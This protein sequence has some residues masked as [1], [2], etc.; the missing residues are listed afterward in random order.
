MWRNWTICE[1]VLLFRIFESI[2]RFDIQS[3]LIYIGTNATLNGMG[4]GVHSPCCSPIISLAGFN[5]NNAACGF[6]ID[7]PDAQA[8]LII[9]RTHSPI[10]YP[11]MLQNTNPLLYFS[12][13]CIY[14]CIYIHCVLCFS[15]RESLA[16]FIRY[17]LFN[18][19]IEKMENLLGC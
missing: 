9:S 7:M 5:L 1:E 8:R 4:R 3:A 14:V 13:T 6:Y 19:I 2:G 15:T 17:F 16:P 18:C 12:F 11:S 10:R